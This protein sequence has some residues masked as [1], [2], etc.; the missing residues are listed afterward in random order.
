MA[1]LVK[2]ENMRS[3]ISR[4]SRWCA[5]LALCILLFCMYVRTEVWLLYDQLAI[6]VT[7]PVFLSQL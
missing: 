4:W 5:L 6:A 7:C 1:L 2:D 3:R